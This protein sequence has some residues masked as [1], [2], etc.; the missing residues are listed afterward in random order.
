M[1]P[2]ASDSR[3]H[4]RAGAACPASMSTSSTPPVHRQGHEVARA[5]ATFL[6]LSGHMLLMAPVLNGRNGKLPSFYKV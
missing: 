6:A 1:W 3:T 5:Q 4:V 2:G